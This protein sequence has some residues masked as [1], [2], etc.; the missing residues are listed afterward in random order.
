VPLRQRTRRSSGPHAQ[1]GEL[2]MAGH[3][4]NTLHHSHV[5]DIG[6][7]SSVEVPT[8]IRIEGARGSNP[9]SSTQKRR[10]GL[11]SR[12]CGALIKIV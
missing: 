7:P 2:G 8:L 9:L 3:G 11:C 10:S 4:L 6:A 5:A 12:A 1:D